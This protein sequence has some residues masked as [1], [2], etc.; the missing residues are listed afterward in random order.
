MRKRG[1]FS[2]DIFGNLGSPVKSS[3]TEYKQTTKVCAFFVLCGEQAATICTH[4]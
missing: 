2:V 1:L 4:N 3:G